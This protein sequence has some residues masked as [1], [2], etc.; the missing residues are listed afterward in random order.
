[1]IGADIGGIPELVADGETGLLVEAGNA[2]GLAEALVALAALPPTARAAM[3][4][5][6][7]AWVG[8]EFSP[9]QYRERTLNLYE[10]IC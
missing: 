3:G 2:A 9:D 7:R 4:A 10:A 8:R 1:M 5:A 6:G